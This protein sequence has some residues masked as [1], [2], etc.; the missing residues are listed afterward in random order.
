MTPTAP[1]A[2]N[3]TS[4]QERALADALGRRRKRLFDAL[5]EARAILHFVP[6][7]LHRADLVQRLVDV[8]ADVGHARLAR[9]R[10]RAHAP[11]VEQDRRDHQRH[12]SSTSAVSLGL[13]TISITRLPSM[14]RV[15]RART[16]RSSRSRLRAAKCRW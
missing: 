7:G 9:A 4:D 13:V 8:D 6:V 1:K 12:A 11:P 2:S 15:L 16:K 5:A 14:I 10:Q 3:I